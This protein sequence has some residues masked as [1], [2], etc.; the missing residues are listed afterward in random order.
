[1]LFRSIVVAQNPERKFYQVDNFIPWER[2]DFAQMIDSKKIIELFQQH[3]DIFTSFIFNVNDEQFTNWRSSAQ[4]PHLSVDL[5]CSLLEKNIDLSSLALSF[6]PDKQ[7]TALLAGELTSPEQ[8]REHALA[9]WPQELRT[10][11][12]DDELQ[13]F[14]QIGRA[15][16]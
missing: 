1:M 9:T 10:N 5:L 13:V 4:E 6:Q 15:H 8:V 2:L 11:L 3:Q 7:A 14:L 12:Q 16:V